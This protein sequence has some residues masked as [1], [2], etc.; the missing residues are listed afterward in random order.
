MLKVGLTGGYASG[1][2]FVASEL[3]RLGCFLIY[4]DE[5]GHEVL[6]QGRE[7]Y[8][9]VVHLF[10]PEILSGEGIID[11]KK[12]G[13]IVFGSP[14]LLNKLTEIVHPA[15]FR[16]EAELLETAKRK[17]PRAIA[18]IEAAI[19]IETGRYRVFDRLILTACSEA[20]Q[21][22]R[23][24]ARDRLSAEDVKARIDKQLPLEEKKKY[25]DYV[26]NTDGTKEETLRQ[27][28]VVFRDLQNL[29]GAH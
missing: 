27:V 2:S 24:M 16:L 12:L 21:I 25:A 22:A 11:R 15:V 3:A 4:A 17:D 18:V 23:G 9:P 6:R 28:E 10:G 7:A 29:S 19:L 13:Q 1:K 26:V 14:D 5:L 20:T 8:E